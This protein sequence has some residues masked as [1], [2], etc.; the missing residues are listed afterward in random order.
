MNADYPAVVAFEKMPVVQLEP[1]SR[2]RRWTE[3]ERCPT[4][5]PTVNS[6]SRSSDKSFCWVKFEFQLA[7]LKSRRQEKAMPYKNR[8][9]S[10]E[11]Y[12]DH[13]QLRSTRMLPGRRWFL[14][15]GSVTLCGFECLCI[16]FVFFTSKYSNKFLCRL[17]EQLAVSRK[18]AEANDAC[19]FLSCQ[20][21]F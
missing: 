6:R 18:S 16:Q 5:Q 12:F 8:K 13:R 19:E 17:F 3:Q 15:S 11:K 4:C 21:L 14:C 9:S 1:N 2:R 7:G 20:T 10:K